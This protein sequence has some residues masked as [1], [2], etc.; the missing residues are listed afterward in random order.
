MWMWVFCLAFAVFGLDELV[1]HAG[2]HRAW[3]EE[4]DGGNDIFKTARFEVEKELFEAAI[5]FSEDET[6]DVKTFES[7]MK[8][9]DG[10]YKTIWDIPF[11]GKVTL[12]VYKGIAIISEFYIGEELVLRHKAL[13]T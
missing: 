10:V 6:N 11:E 9:E 13:P 3:S 7:F 8:T 12:K 5:L 2:T 1:N 4:G